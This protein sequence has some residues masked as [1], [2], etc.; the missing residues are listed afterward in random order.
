MTPLTSIIMMPQFSQAAR[1]R[2]DSACRSLGS[3]RKE[4]IST[5]FS[6]E[7]IFGDRTPPV[8]ITFSQGKHGQSLVSGG[9]RRNL[10]PS[11]IIQ[12][13]LFGCK[14]MQSH[15]LLDVM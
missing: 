4:D 14:W 9:S 1:S 8:E 3:T 15:I 12:Q 7:D 2:I 5:I 11:T 10:L 6:D 13:R